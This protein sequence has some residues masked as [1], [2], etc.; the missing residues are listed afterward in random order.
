MVIFNPD[1]GKQPKNVWFVLFNFTVCNFFSLVYKTHFI[2]RTLWTKQCLFH[3][4]L[5]S[6]H[7]KDTAPVVNVSNILPL[8]LQ[9]FGTVGADC[10]ICNVHSVFT[11]L[12]FFISKVASSFVL[13][14]FYEAHCL[15]AFLT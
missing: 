11:F 10:S 7:K 15:Y 6:V 12:F 1:D 4:N 2:E 5:I 8:E 13:P 3:T 9:S 14:L